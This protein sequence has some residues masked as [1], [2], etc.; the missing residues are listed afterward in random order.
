MSSFLPSPVGVHGSGFRSLF[1]FSSRSTPLSGISR[2]RQ[3]TLYRMQNTNGTLHS[4]CW[5]K[6]N[7]PSRFSLFCLSLA[8]SLSLSL[9]A[10]F[11]YPA[12]HGRSSLRLF[13]PS[14]AL[15]ARGAS[16]FAIVLM[17]KKKSRFCFPVK[18][19]AVVAA[20]HSSVDL[21]ALSPSCCSSP[22]VSVCFRLFTSFCHRSLSACCAAKK[23][24][25]RRGK[26]FGA[27]EPHLLCQV[28]LF[29]HQLQPFSSSILSPFSYYFLLVLP[30]PSFFFSPLAFSLF[31][32]FQL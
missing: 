5:C 25:K 13:S 29:S 28:A 27:L 7:C 32:A 15:L 12:S 26:E 1:C 16:T 31:P 11:C 6:S 3:R 8:P 19:F 2:W 22:S 14:C 4:F 10:A 20:I 24:K 9:C 18:L 21:S 30:D 17:S 23:R